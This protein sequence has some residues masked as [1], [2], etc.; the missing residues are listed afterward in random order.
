MLFKYLLLSF[1]SWIQ[2]KII[3]LCLFKPDELINYYTKT[4]LYQLENSP[5]LQID[6]DSGIQC[7]FERNTKL[8]NKNLFYLKFLSH[9]MYE[10]LRNEFPKKKIYEERLGYV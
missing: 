8:D 9:K 5:S 1:N 2:F 6:L 7:N 4:K 3:K 10:S